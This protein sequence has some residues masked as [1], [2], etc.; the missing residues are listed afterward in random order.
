[1]KTIP[2]LEK[3]RPLLILGRAANAADLALRR[4]LHAKQRGQSL[5]VVDYQGSLAA[6]LTQRNKGN[7]HKGPLLW[8]DLANRRRPSALFRLAR[9]P[10]MKPAL[11]SFLHNCV[12]H[13]V[14]P[15]SMP[16]IDVAVEL[17]YRMADQGSVGLAALLG[18]LRRPE[19]SH[20]LRSTP[21][22]AA[23]L[24]ALIEL[25][26]W[27]L[28]FPAVWSLSEGNNFV[29]LRHTLTLG[30]TAWIELPG[31]HFERLEH[32]VASW[33]VDAAL[34]DALLSSRDVKSPGEA[35]RLSPI[36]LYGFPIACPLTVESGDI[37]A[38]QVG[39][40]AFSAA[41]PLPAP[42]RHWLDVDADCWVAGDIG[43]L[44]DTART[45]WLDEAERNRLKDLKSG[46]VWVR[47]GANRKAVTALVRPPEAN[48]SLS[49]DFRRQALKRLRLSP[50]KQFS[51][52]V[53]SRDLAAPQNANLYFKLCTKEAL[54]AGWFRVK[55]HNR[56]SY[57][58]D[59]M[60]V[61]Q[62]GT[63]LDIEI[64][65]LV[66][67]MTEGRYR[68][69][70]LRTARIPKP[71]GDF[72]VLKIPCVRDRV[73]QA[74][75]LQL[76]EPLFDSRFS[77]ASFA[78]RPGRGAHHAVAVARSMLRLGKHWVVTADIRKCFDTI[79]HDIVL[80][81]VGDVIGDRDLI[82]LIRHWLATDVIDFMDVIPSELGVPQGAAISPLLA[83]IY[84]DPL[85]KAF[86][87]AGIA[88]VRYADDYVVFCNS[89]PEAQAALRMM[90]EF[91]AGVLRLTLK[92]AKT[93]YCHVQ[94]NVES[95]VGFLGFQIALSDVCLPPAKMD[96]TLH[97]F[98]E[99]VETIASPE[100]SVMEQYLA[101]MQVSSRIKGFRN[102]FLIDDAPSIRT[103]LRELDAA[104]DTL[105]QQRFAVAPDM[106]AVWALRERFLPDTDTAVRNTKTA[107]EVAVLTGAYPQ[108]RPVYVMPPP[109]ATDVSTSNI[110]ATALT[111]LSPS[112]P[113][114]QVIDPDV[115]V[116]DGRL[117]VMTS[118][119]FVTVNGDDVVVRRRKAEIFRMPI[120]G[121]TMVYL[122]GRGIGLSADLTM[123]L[124]DKG[125][126][127]VFTPLV[128]IP[129]AIAQ[130]VQG[131]R[132]D[133]RQ[134]QVL[135]RSAPDILKIGLG[136]LSAKVANQASV[137][138]Y[139][140][141]YRKRTDDVVYRQLT[142][143]ADDIRVI[144]GTLDGLDP[145]AANIRATAMGHEGRAAAKYW[146]S[147]AVLM[148]T[149][150]SFPGRHTR[151]ATDPVN[152]AI[153][154][155][156]GMLYGEVW[157]AVIRAGL[158]PYFGI[159]HG[160]ERDQGSLVFDLIE[161][162]RAPVGDRL[163]LGML[164][165]GF[166]LELDKDGRLRAASRYKLVH[167]FH[168]QWQRNVS[169]RGKMRTPSDILEMQ[170][171]SLKNAYLGTDEYR[172][173]RFRW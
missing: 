170:V 5:V 123:G 45:D 60:T 166:A 144:A 120:A 162:Y 66:K 165:R 46:E 125:I 8:C 52:S 6:H 19:T 26:A 29:D 87:Q 103:Q 99:I 17:A 143:C 32:Q 134:Q 133:L 90:S 50:V 39:L 80:R 28:R 141:R 115:L 167:A 122:E 3:P 95:G 154:Y 58:Y 65:Q 36:V 107:A 23:E 151:H 168:K 137:L 81:L 105:A 38:K 131:T 47:S 40:F 169:W 13:M 140:A 155:V 97:A 145:T 119:C 30:G 35:Q 108:D 173:F 129:A 111:A 14:A 88:F 31:A 43:E 22:L 41:Q 83:N 4:I 64:D 63:V 102:Y 113:V 11:K 69:R 56:H 124:C 62:F 79:D 159:I 53:T 126:S 130:P 98:A 116:I 149:A 152:S 157:R 91:L 150:L 136:M 18:C 101:V 84:L 171:T 16:T 93:N 160:T 96:R 135:R 138:K 77:S 49:L 82:Q 158:D 21:S 57:G 24:D 27:M 2:S 163:V 172:P 100:A 34:M 15:V 59:L 20:G 1:M 48:T 12:R 132:S 70:P 146:T 78:Y 92:S 33:M 139:F 153:N 142:G 25:L 71:D 104:V 86:E 117:H 9:S 127:V 121:L 55:T 54:Y 74:A 51:S 7:L 42:A 61:E 68:S 76:V 147:L 156:Y 106:A 89:E 109:E 164:G 114:G 67:E 75:C 37:K 94:K 110:N 161:E 118:G 112:Q 10:G 85:D 73:V 72:R 148:P 128:G 44:A